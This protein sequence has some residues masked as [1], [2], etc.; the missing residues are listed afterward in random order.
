VEADRTNKL[1][2]VA[3]ETSIDLLLMKL[4]SLAEPAAP[5]GWR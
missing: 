2:E 5:R 1:G 3:E 4:C